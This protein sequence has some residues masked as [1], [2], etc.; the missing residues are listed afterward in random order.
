MSPTVLMPSSASRF[1]VTLPTPG[2]RPMGS[3]GRNV[4]Q[5]F[6]LN[7][8]EAVG[9]APIRSDLGQEFVR[10]NAG[11]SG[12]VQ[13]VANLLANGASNPGRGGQTGFVFG[14][15]EVGLVQRQGFNQISVTFEYLPGTLG[16]GAVAREIRRD[17]DRFG[18]QTL[19]ADRR[20][21]RAHA[22]L[23]RFVGG[24][25]DDGAVSFPR[26]HHRP[27]AQVRVVP[28]LDGSIKR[29]HIDVDDFAAFHPASIVLADQGGN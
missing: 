15:V 2:M 8:K 1:S 7:H 12:Q 23:A 4:V 11:R 20:H 6:G 3:G 29:V 16:D 13:F 10:S 26:D 18:A 14:Y 22:E 9:L 25:A 5:V 19:G 27:A 24:G 21:S 28:L 17:K